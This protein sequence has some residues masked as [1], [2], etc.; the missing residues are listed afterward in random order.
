MQ[1]ISL[2]VGGSKVPVVTVNAIQHRTPN[3][4][5][6][7]PWHCCINIQMTGKFPS[8]INRSTDMHEQKSHIILYTSNSVAIAEPS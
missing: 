4:G 1:V 8:Y 2:C 6:V 5:H 3:G 7:F